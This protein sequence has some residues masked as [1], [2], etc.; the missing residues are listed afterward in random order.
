MST[1]TA[2]KRK[3]LGQIEVMRVVAMTGIFLY[4]LWSDV[5]KA[6]TEN[7][8]GPAFGVILSGGW[9]GVILFNI[10]TGFVLTL[11]VAGPQGRPMPGYLDFLRHRF[12]RI[13]PNYYVG[14]V[15][16]SLV[17]IVAGKAGAGFVSSFTQHLFFVH[18]LNPSVFFDIVPAYWWMG[19]LAQFYL[20]YPLLWKLFTR[21]GPRRAATWMVGGCFGLW[22]LL[23]LLA[24][25]MP[26]SIF[27]MGNYLFYFNLP[28]RLAE[29]AIGMYLACL[30][31]DPAANPV[32]GQG[33]S[34]CEAFG[35][36]RLAALAGLSLL[37]NWG[38]MF[39]VPGPVL[40]ITHLYWLAVVFCTGL[41]I[42]FSS[43]M[44]KLGQWGPIAKFAAASYSIYLMHQPIIG[45]L[46]GWLSPHM[47]PFTAFVVLTIVCGTLSMW[48]ALYTDKIV[49]AINQRIG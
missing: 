21:L 35:R 9:M 2:S 26:G 22:A 12:L 8:F 37:V 47:Q 13:C 34:L 48:A 39:G 29:F 25:L 31:R 14:L 23:E 17:A 20:A 41:L 43:S 36:Q 4:H 45:Y 16:W 33:K 11:P 49:A 46:A 19:L 1:P 24:K 7:P 32:L 15:F 40:L 30:W 5:P 38:L 10:V 42:F 18:T 27:A 44:D 28:Y 6:G 3:T